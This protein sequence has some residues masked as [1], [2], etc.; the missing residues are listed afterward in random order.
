[1]C[2]RARAQLPEASPRRGLIEWATPTLLV[3]GPRLPLFNRR[4]PFA[5]VA[6]VPEP[7]LDPGV[8]V[9]RVGEFVGRRRAER[10][11][12]RILGGG[13]AGLVVHGIGGVGKSSLAAELVRALGSHELMVSK[14]GAVSVDA[15]LDEV[16]AQLLASLGDGQADLRQ[17]AA[18]LRRADVEWTD[19]WPVLA[20]LAAA[21]PMVVLLDNFEDNLVAEGGVWRVRDGELAALLARW[22]RQPGRS[23]LLLTCRH[24]FELPDGAARRLGWHHLG[25]LSVAETA[26]LI[27]QLPGL[28][29][30]TPAERERA[31]RDVGGHPVALASQEHAGILLTSPRRMPG[32]RRRLGCSFAPS[33]SIRPRT[34]AKTRC[35]G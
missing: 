26:K 8:V 15:V 35:S 18:A 24:P 22:A 2:E 3:R 21:V 28:D 34:P 25:P 12:R 30:L 32:A 14:A 20:R 11:C 19:R 31:W 6:A 29:A 16:G 13:K 23:R 10:D 9:R 5:P 1:M 17:A 7:V 27:W 33:T 4:E